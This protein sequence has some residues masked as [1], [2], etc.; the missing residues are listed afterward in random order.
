MLPTLILNYSSHHE[1]L[2]KT[3]PDFKGLKV[4]TNRKKYT[5]MHMRQQL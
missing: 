4:S 5:D 1:M 2:Y 3:P